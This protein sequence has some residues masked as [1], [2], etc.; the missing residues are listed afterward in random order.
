HDRQLQAGHPER[1]PPRSPHR[2]RPYLCRLLP[3][4]LPEVRW[5]RV[6]QAAEHQPARLRDRLQQPH[7]RLPRLRRRRRVLR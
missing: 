2:F 6:L 5:L 4:G 1:G 3:P 7:R